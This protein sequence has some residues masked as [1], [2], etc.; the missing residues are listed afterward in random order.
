MIIVERTM[1]KKTI[2]ITYNELKSNVVI[3]RLSFGEMNQVN[4]DSTDVKVING[5][6]I[7]KISQKALKE[8]GLLRSI[9]EAPFTI[10]LKNIQDL[11][12]ETG[13]LLFE[14]FSELN[15]QDLKKNA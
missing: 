12:S 15:Q 4:E 8:Q 2:E 5:Q 6:P 13:N 14:E 11:D 10:D 3:K 7:I 1:I 9:I